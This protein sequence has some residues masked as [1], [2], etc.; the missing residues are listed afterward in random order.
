MSALENFRAEK[1]ALFRDGPDSP[2]TE[3]QRRGFAGL[4]YF[5]ESVALRIVARPEPFP[6]AVRV[7]IDLSGGDTAEYERWARVHFEVEGEPAELTVYRDPEG[8]DL[9]LPFRDTTAATGETYGAGRYVD[10][11]QLVDGSLVID[12]NYAYN[13]YCAYND[14]WTC[15]LT[16]P[17]NALGVPVRAGERAFPADH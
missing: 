1:D 14:E 11:Q 12:F 9:F 16:P 13:P 10:V 6:L 17:E 15:P 3:E 5:P 2:L 7:P 4:V 8:G